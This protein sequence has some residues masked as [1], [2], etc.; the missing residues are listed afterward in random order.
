[1]SGVVQR[2]LSAGRERKLSACG[3]F[4]PDWAL[5]LERRKELKL[6]G[7]ARRAFKARARA[8]RDVAWHRRYL[9]VLDWTD[10]WPARAIAQALHCAVSTVYNVLGRFRQRGE[11]GLVDAREDNGQLKVDQEYLYHL[12]K[13]LEK[14]PQEYGYPRP[15]WTRELLV[16]V[17]VKLTG[18]R[19]H[20]ATMSRVL[21]VLGARRG[22]PRPVVLS[23]MSKAARQRMIKKIERLLRSVP[24]REIV[25]Y[26]D[27][28]DIHL[29]PKIGF[30]WM[31]PGTQ[32]E[33]VTPGI[34]QKRYIAG[35]MKGWCEKLFWVIG[36]RKRSALFVA[37]LFLIC[38][39]LR[40]YRRIHIILDNCRIHKSKQTQTALKALGGKVVLHF[41]PPYCPEENKIERLWL[42]LHDNVTRNHQCEGIEDLVEN[43]ENF[44]IEKAQVSAR[45][46]MRTEAA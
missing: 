10:G 19:I 9:I 1:M 40:W 16:E 36:E 28:A 33:V 3:R 22:R 2:R 24:P 7:R 38:R 32:K 6:T 39:E 23:P 11:V 31:L 18:V 37:L 26:C 35:A 43:V 46:V 15:T 17:M 20:P 8:C 27:E 42:D 41:L 29:N 34:N 5:K 12:R 13:V 45:A 4:R 14:S 25:L 21:R 44:L 30:D